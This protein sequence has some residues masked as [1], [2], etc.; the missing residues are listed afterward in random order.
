MALARTDSV[1]GMKRLALLLPIAALSGCMM[2]DSIS[3][4][5]RLG[6]Q[7]HALNDEVRWGRVDLAAQRVAPSHRAAFVAS[8]RAWG[9]EVHVAD[10]DVTNMDLG[11][12]GGRAASYV[13]YSWIDEHT[14]E[15]RATTVRQI[16]RG[17]NEGFVLVSE[18]ILSG[19]EAL[20]PGVPRAEAAEG[21]VSDE[22]AITSGDEEAS[23]P[24]AQASSTRPV[25]AQ[26][27]R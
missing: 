3:P 12:E 24:V 14:M 10:A 26:G 8:H 1:G 23:E 20:L 16:W 15:L 6:D 18:E 19:D 17:E 27:M 5:V 25:D 2:I 4:E 11:L 13:N 21:A 22:G 9:S 7:V